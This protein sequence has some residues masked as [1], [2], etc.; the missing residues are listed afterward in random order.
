MHYV[1]IGCGAA[2]LHAAKSIH[3]YDQAGDISLISYEFK[4]FYIKPALV[5]FLAGD[6]RP[7][8]LLYRETSPLVT[9]DRVE[10]L[11]GKRVR[12]VIPSAN[13]IQ[14]SNGETLS[15]TFL[16]IATGTRP[17]LDPSMMQHADKI[18]TVNTF[19]DALRL[20]TRAQEANAV[21]VYGGGYRALELV[22]ALYR[23]NIQVTYLT[24]S[25]RFW[26]LDLPGITAG[27]LR[28]K[29][30]ERD[31]LLIEDDPIVDI[32]DVDG[33]TYRVITS[34]GR[35]ID[36]QLIITALGAEPSVEF[37]DGSGV[38]IDRG[39]LVAEDMR[40]NISNIY[41]AGDVAQVYDIN[42]HLNRMNFGW[43]SAGE[44]GT[45]AGGNMAGRSD[46]YIPDEDTYFLQLYGKRLLDR[47]A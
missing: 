12:G 38:K 35:E 32:L 46:V 37:L 13:E 23:K 8:S 20:R 3:V 39:I 36:A 16:L 29:L 18:L 1:I 14:F 34:L 21:A 47:W 11:T 25:D 17:R 6:V 19:T 33:A 43:L 7:H 27:D 31:I 5:D 40:T 15:Y 22:R 42:R 26:P 28:T 2:G 10:L 4:P 30:K 9:L 45:M 41:A 24:F 44:Q